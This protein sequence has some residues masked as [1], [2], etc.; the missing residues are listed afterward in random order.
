MKVKSESS[1]GC[2]VVSGTGTASWG[3]AGLPGLNG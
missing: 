2:G 1:G 3:A